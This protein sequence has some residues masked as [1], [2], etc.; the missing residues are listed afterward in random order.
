MNLSGKI[1][2]ITGAGKGIGESITKKALN[3]GGVVYAVTR[4]KKDLNEYRNSKN[5]HVVYGDITKI[6]IIKKIFV[7]AKKNN[8]HIN[9]LVNNAGMRQRKKLHDFNEKDIRAIFEINFFSQFF[10]TLEFIKNF[11]YKK[12]VK[13][14]IVNISSIVGQKGFKELIGYASTKTALIGM[15]NSLAVELAKKDIRSNLISPGFIKSS[16]YQKFKKNKKLYKW[17]LDKTPVGR[18]GNVDEVSELVCFLLSDSS[19]YITGEN[20]KIDGGWSVA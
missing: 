13:G 8:H 19:S 1:I 3:Y 6:E 20:I 10:C 12:K 16:Y 7:L 11:S 4:S 18:W 14:S 2:L 9:C 15:S 17:T 5:C